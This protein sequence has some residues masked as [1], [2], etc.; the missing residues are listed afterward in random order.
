M[1]SITSFIGENGASL[2]AEAPFFCIKCP[3]RMVHVIGVN[4]FGLGIRSQDL[5]SH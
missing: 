2:D 1:G 4:E 5:G 3:Y